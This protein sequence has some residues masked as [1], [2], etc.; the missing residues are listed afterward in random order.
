[1]PEGYVIPESW[2]F[3]ISLIIRGVLEIIAAFRI[4]ATN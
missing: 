1:M 2:K 4:K 3:G